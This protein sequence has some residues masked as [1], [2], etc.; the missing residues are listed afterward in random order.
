LRDLLP[1]FEAF[2]NNVSFNE[3]KDDLEFANSKITI[4]FKDAMSKAK[5]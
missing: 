5:K 4:L 1:K 2:L 3:I